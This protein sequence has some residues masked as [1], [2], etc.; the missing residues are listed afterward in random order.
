MSYDDWLGLV[1]EEALEPDLLICDPHHHLWD[2]PDSMPENEVPVFTRSKRH[3]LLPELMSDLSSGHNI[4]STVFVE[5]NSMYRK[6]KDVLKHVGETEFV[7]GIAAQ[8][9]SGQYGNTDVAAGIVGFADLRLGSAIGAVLDAHVFA[10]D[11]FRGVRFISTF[12]KAGFVA[13]RVKVTALLSDEK[14][15]KGFAELSKRNLNFDA[16]LYHNQLADLIDLARS[17]PD[18]TIILDHIGGPIGVGPYAA[19]RQEVIDEWK[20]GIADLA[21]CPNAFIKLGGLGMA[22][23]GFGWSQDAQPP[24]SQELAKAM[25][26]F[27][28]WCIEKFEVNRCMFESNSPVDREAYSYVVYWNACKRFSK[29]YS[30]TERAALFHDTAVAVYSLKD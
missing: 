26:P 6:G 4:V 23:M 3:Y 30:E 8:A 14:F 17:F 16:W 25:D 7:N 11:R 28:T 22:M 13:S 29:G 19:R 5:C 21:A 10:S 15:R 2:Y 1:R 12:D 9:A 20:Q 24:D 18:T 27:F